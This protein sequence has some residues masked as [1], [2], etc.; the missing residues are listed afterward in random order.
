[1]K[2]KNKHTV[3]RGKIKFK[4]HDHEKYSQDKNSYYFC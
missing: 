2:L 3:A 1:M 4:V